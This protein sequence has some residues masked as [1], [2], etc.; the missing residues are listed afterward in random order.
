MLTDR[1]AADKRASKVLGD[2][3]GKINAALRAVAVSRQ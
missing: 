2:A 1:Q 3:A